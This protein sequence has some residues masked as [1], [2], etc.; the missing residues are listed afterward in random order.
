MVQNY[1]LRPKIAFMM[2]QNGRKEIQEHEK[3]LDPNNIRDFVDGYLLEIQKKSGDPKTTFRKE[4]LADLS[5]AFFAAGSETVRM[6]VDWMLLV[7]ATYPEVQK[8]I[9]SEIDEVLGQERFPT[10]ND[11]LSMPFTEAAIAELMRW[12]TTVPLNIMR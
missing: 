6:T 4:V 1:Q 7:C 9:H 11:H 2:L 12:K 10:R 5:R 8:K 3:T